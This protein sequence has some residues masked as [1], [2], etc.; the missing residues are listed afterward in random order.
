M[1]FNIV[2]TRKSKLDYSMC[3]FIP[4]GICTIPSNVAL[5][6][7]FFWEASKYV[8]LIPSAA[9][10]GPVFDD[11]VLPYIKGKQKIKS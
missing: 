1:K 7:G 5:T 3:N 9:V 11:G 4:L 10:D 6:P 2:E 8:Y